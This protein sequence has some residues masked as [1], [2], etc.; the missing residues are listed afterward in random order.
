[1]SLDPLLLVLVAATFVVAGLVK[2]V[3]GMGMPTVSLALLAATVGLPSAMALL[4][5]PTIVT[6][7]WQALVGGYLRQILRRL[8]PFLVASVVTV[9]LG[10]GILARVDVRWL[11]GLLGV[12]L[13][14]YALAGLFNLGLAA[15]VSRGRYAAPVNGALTGLL[16]G[17]TGSSV[18]P[19]VAY[20][21]SLGLPR[22]MLIQAMGV[23]FVVTTTALGLSMGEQRLL[24]MELGA[25]SLGAV[26][27]AIVG[28]QLGQR[29]RQRLS[30]TTFRRVFLSGLLAMG[31]YLL[32]RSLA[33]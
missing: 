25:L 29:L 15:L 17:M 16:T 27:P 14:F 23:L 21:Q 3:I 12:L 18:F 33:G 13:A 32:V 26:V 19:G 7:V 4:L 31:V 20:L 10:V 2:G 1:M 5:V 22:D 11:S 8:W 28:M 9:W 30:E 6:N 24:S